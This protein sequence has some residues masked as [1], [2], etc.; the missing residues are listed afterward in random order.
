MLKRVERGTSSMCDGL[1][2]DNN[3]AFNNANGLNLTLDDAV[4]YVS[5]LSDAARGQSLS[6]GLKNSLFITFLIQ[7]NGGSMSSA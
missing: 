5:F 7:C 3:D 2:P 6:T 4:S 1:D